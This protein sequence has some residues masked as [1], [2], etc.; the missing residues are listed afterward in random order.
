MAL[1]L[2]MLILI[3]VASAESP[4]TQ[5]KQMVEQLQQTP[6]DNVLREKVIGLALEL[7][8][9]PVIPDAAIM[10]EGAG[11]YAFKNAKSKSDYSDAAKQYEKAL[12]MAPWLADD[13]FN[14][15]VAHERAGEIQEAIRSFNI[16]LLAAPHAHDALEIKKR[17]GGLQYELQKAENASNA[18]AI[19][20][21]VRSPPSV[22][23]GFN[24]QSLDGPAFGM[25]YSF[26]FSTHIVTSRL[27][28]ANGRDA[29]PS[30]IRPLSFQES[31]PRL[32]WSTPAD[33]TGDPYY[34]Q[35]TLNRDVGLIDVVDPHGQLHA[36]TYKC[37]MTNQ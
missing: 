24:C 21:V 12:A 17:I 2:G 37:A 27:L 9:K 28:Y 25:K 10:A 29:G 20:N 19:Q 4:R 13:Y 5:L 6:N 14:C 33:D 32:I 18:P 31:G 26:D 1:F 36:S 11:E 34:F 7:K 15:G 30:N 23:Q 22:I 3:N 16:Y 35:S 8:P